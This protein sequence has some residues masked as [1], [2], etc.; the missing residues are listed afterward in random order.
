MCP[1]DMALN[2]SYITIPRMDS[3]L[4]HC[5]GIALGTS[6]LPPSKKKSE[7][8][9]ITASLAGLY[10]TVYSARNC[11]LLETHHRNLSSTEW[12]FW[13]AVEDVLLD[14]DNLLSYIAK[15]AKNR[16][17]TH[18]WLQWLSSLI[19][20]VPKASAAREADLEAATEQSATATEVLRHE[21]L[22]SCWGEVIM[23]VARMAML[24]AST[25]PEHLLLGFKYVAPSLLL[26]LE[27]FPSVESS[28]S[29]RSCLRHCSPKDGKEEFSLAVQLLRG[30]LHSSAN[31]VQHR[32][33]HRV[34][35]DDGKTAG[36][37]CRSLVCPANAE[38]LLDCIAF[39]T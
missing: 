16:R 18:T 6:I 34:V 17:K 25:G 36:F 29:K 28:G 35:K 10:T 27:S 5:S 30:F 32:S 23:L 26:V 13:H 9:S 11:I 21:I 7:L 1:G 39:E 20:P 12:A 24:Q 31:A 15:K 8:Q 38:T 33:T 2:F 14:C 19:W 37:V 3:I 4:R 22:L